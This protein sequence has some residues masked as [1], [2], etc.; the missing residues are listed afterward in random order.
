MFKPL[1]TILFVS[2]FACGGG[3]SAPSKVTNA[4]EY[5]Q[6]MTFM[7][8]KGCSLMGGD[9]CTKM[10]N[11][12]KSFY[13]SNKALIESAEAWKKEHKD[14]EKKIEEEMMPKI[15]EKAGPAMAAAM[16]CE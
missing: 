12:L 11:D 16:K 10:G 15:M 2:L 5:K 7:M 13:D 3:G 8:D 1:T 14:E 4:D 9:D 6:A